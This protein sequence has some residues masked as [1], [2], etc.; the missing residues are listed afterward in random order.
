[1]SGVRASLE[2][3]AQ[4]AKARS[5]SIYGIAA[6]PPQFLL[7]LEHIA[8]STM[9][10]SFDSRVDVRGK[11]E[12]GELCPGGESAVEVHSDYIWYSSHPLSFSSV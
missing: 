3:S 2:S 1:M 8:T 6:A 9:G 11:V 12:R 10:G 5:K 7:I 4:V